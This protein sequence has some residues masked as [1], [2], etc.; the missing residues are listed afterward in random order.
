M[1]YL[2]RRTSTDHIYE[3]LSENVEYR[4]S[5]MPKQKKLIRYSKIDYNFLQYLSI[6]TKWALQNH[7]I[8]QTKL[9][10]LLYIYPIAIFSQE[11]FKE[12]QAEL[13]KANNTIFVELKRD[14]WVKLWSKDKGK[15]FYVLSNKSNL[16][17][18]RMHNM[19]LL[20]EPIPMSLSRNVTAKGTKKKDKILMDLYKKFNQKVKDKNK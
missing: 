8:T 16:L 13:G 19:L 4:R 15:S 14:G 1:N 17:V 5:P 7:N 12:M 10:L 9:D 11:Y 20:Q 6:V 2:T 3:R 18:S